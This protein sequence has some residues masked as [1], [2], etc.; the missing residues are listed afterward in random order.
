MNAL[1]HVGVIMDGNRRW[2]RKL[3]MKSVLNGH[4]Q[5]VKKLIDLCVWCLDRQIPFLSVYAFSTENWGRDKAEIDG[6]FLLMKK[7]FEEE[8]QN[9]IEKGIRIVV[10]GDLSRLKEPQRNIIRQ[11]EEK[12]KDC[13]SLQLQI[14]ISYGGRDELTRA[15]RKMVNAARQGTLSEAN[16]T[17]EVV[18]DY[19]D[20]A[21]TPMIDMVIRTGGC[22]RLSN[23]FVWQTAYSEL[24]FTDTLWPEFTEK[25]FADFIEM[26]Q[27][28]H[29]NMGK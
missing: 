1:T 13:K 19:L 9:C 17:E 12:T 6:L 3:G 22:H 11:A 18:A 10:V 14:A 26:Y 15:V 21:G 20:T 27:S 25:E 29:I 5:G 28:V 7:F 8:I 16:I 24:Y 23:F 2:A 4:E